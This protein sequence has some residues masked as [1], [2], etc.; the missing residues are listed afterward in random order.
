MDEFNRA[1]EQYNKALGIDSLYP[2][3][4]TGL[5]ELYDTYLYVK[6]FQNKLE[7][8]DQKTYGKKRDSCANKAYHLAPYLPQTLMAKGNYYFSLAATT[9]N[10]D[11]AFF[12]LKKAYRVAPNDAQINFNISRFYNVIGLFYQARPYMEKARQ[13]NPISPLP[14]LPIVYNYLT[15]GD[16]DEAEKYANEGL[17]LNPMKC[18]C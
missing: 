10:H 2:Q 6:L 9:G 8:G 17:Q 16:F 18:F 12:Y 13:L 14:Y 7:P 3:A 4:Y 5:S 11:S 1:K 15:L